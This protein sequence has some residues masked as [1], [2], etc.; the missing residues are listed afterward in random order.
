MPKNKVVDR[1]LHVLTA[2]FILAIL[3]IAI[4]ILPF[5]RA[6]NKSID[7][8]I[9]SSVAQLRMLA[10]M[11]YGISNESYQDLCLNNKLN[12]NQKNY[13][14][15]IDLI[16]SY[17]KKQ[18]KGIPAICYAEEKRYCVQAVLPVME[19]NACADSS[20]TMV[21]GGYCDNL[22][23]DCKQTPDENYELQEK[24]KLINAENRRQ[25]KYKNFINDIKIFSILLTIFVLIPIGIVTTIKLSKKKTDK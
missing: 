7:V 16:D 15:E 22:N 19:N 11:V 8:A 1:I 21:I 23:Y 20:G 24:Y 6:R 13:S 14:K 18:T 9:Q 4:N 2:L 10:E 17:I 5:D 3:V 12:I 25:Q